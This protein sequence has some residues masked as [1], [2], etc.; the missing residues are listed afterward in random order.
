MSHDDSLTVAP[1]LTGVAGQRCLT[2]DQTL[3]WIPAA[4]Q[5]AQS[6]GF[7]GALFLSQGCTLGWV[8][9]ARQAAPLPGVPGAKNSGRV[10]R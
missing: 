3:G 7:L 9:A 4:L 6:W 2:Q 8:P 5:A 1:R 10:E